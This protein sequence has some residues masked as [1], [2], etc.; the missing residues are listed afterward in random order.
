MINK[1]KTVLIPLFIVL[2][3]SNISAQYRGGQIPDFDAEKA[4]GIFQYESKK[5]FKKLKV[6]DKEAKQKVID[7][8]NEYNQKMTQLSFDHAET[9]KNLEN[10]FDANIKLAIQ[11]RDRGQMDGVKAEIKRTI[12]PIRRQVQA[13]EQVLND[14]MAAT[15]T[16]EQYFIWL[17]YQKKKKPSTEL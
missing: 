16:E 8:L 9:F 4:A 17:K 13:E 15:L 7:A 14:A 6:D 2:F 12:P 11:R 10:S 5:V 3:I 1:L